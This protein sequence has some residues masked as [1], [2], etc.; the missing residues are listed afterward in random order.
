MFIYF[1]QDFLMYL[2]IYPVQTKK[3]A[4][5]IVEVIEVTKWNISAMCWLV[6][7]STKHRL[8]G[9]SVLAKSNLNINNKN[10]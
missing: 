9:T 8:V 4:Q 10:V 7:S 1:I 3:K 5:I 6:N 2:N